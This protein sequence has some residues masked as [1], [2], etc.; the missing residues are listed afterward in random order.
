VAEQEFGICKLLDAEDM[1]S[2]KPDDK[3]VMTYVAYYWKAFQQYAQAE[4]AARRVGNM[5]ARER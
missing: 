1:V 4:V 2:F 3:S 5:V